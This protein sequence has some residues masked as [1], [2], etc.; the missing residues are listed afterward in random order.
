MKLLISFYNGRRATDCAQRG[1][2]A[3]PRAPE[4]T[5]DE[6][7]SLIQAVEHRKLR[8]FDRVDWQAP[9]HDMCS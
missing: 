9:M 7:P 5:I 8:C 2:T 4:R 1:M 3:V 6:I